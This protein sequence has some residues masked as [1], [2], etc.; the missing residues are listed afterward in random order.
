VSLFRRYGEQYDIDWLLMV[1]QGYQESRLDQSLRSR[2]GAMGVMQLMPSTGKLMKVGDVSELDGNIHAGVK[3]MRLI[4][5]SYFKDASI[6]AVNKLLFTFAAYNAGPTRISR[7][8]NEARAKKLNP[9]VWFDNVERL[10]AEQIGPETVQYVANI[11]KYYIAYKLVQDDM[12]RDYRQL[13][14]QS[15]SQNAGRSNLQKAQ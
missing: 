2:V 8:R 1:A 6:D 10:A 13:T 4:L 15:D 14:G 12:E 5:D 9:D 11:Y 3:Y 7:L